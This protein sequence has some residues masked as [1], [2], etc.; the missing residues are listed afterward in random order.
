MPSTIVLVV[1]HGTSGAGDL[2][3]ADTGVIESVI[4][5]GVK[6]D[7]KDTDFGKACLWLQEQGYVPA[8][9]KWI[10]RAGLTRRRR[11]TYVKEA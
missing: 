8:G 10:E 6:R 2:A 3:R 1:K 4:L 11:C 7:P 9:F 5:D